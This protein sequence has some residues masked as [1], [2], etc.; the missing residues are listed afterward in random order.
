[1]KRTKADWVADILFAVFIIGWILLL[2]GVFYKILSLILLG[3][4]IEVLLA[5]VLRFLKNRFEV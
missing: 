2:A 1:V 5:V 3:I 4:V